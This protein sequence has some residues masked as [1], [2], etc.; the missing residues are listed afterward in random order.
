MEEVVDLFC[1]DSDDHVESDIQ[2]KQNLVWVDLNILPKQGKAIGGHIISIAG[3]IEK[4]ESFS[5]VLNSTTKKF[6]EKTVIVS[7][8]DSWT[9]S[10]FNKSVNRCCN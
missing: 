2:K 8:E 9:Y 6:P 5:E 4:K 3:E 1:C 10:N 7:G